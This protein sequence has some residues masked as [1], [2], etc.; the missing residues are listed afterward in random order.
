MDEAL[1]AF[2][3]KLKKEKDL[4]NVKKEV[5]LLKRKRQALVD[6]E[7]RIQEDLSKGQLG[8]V[9]S[10]K[11]PLSVISQSTINSAASASLSEEDVR[12]LQHTAK[13][14]QKLQAVAICYGVTSFRDESEDETKFMFDP[15][16]A[17]QPYGPYTLRI[18]FSRSVQCQCRLTWR[19]YFPH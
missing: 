14:K 1:L 8:P 12:R 6:R 19:R 5:R 15:Y 16:I 10:Y 11:L 17:G 4:Q 18:R 13:I 7:N 3:E 9:S 2:D